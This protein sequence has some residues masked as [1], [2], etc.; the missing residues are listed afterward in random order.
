MLCRRQANAIEAQMS[1]YIATG[2][3]YKKNEARRNLFRLAGTPKRY[4]GTE[5]L[6]FFRGIYVDGISDVQIGSGATPFSQY[7][8]SGQR[9][10][11]RR[12]NEV[13]APLVDE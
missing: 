10:R 8:L 6:T 3:R 2:A 4:V 9:L 13:I 7:I 12:V 5:G 1:N 11:K